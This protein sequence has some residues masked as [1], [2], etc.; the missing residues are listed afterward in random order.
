MEDG[1]RSERSKPFVA[2]IVEVVAT[3][4]VCATAIAL[5]ISIVGNDASLYLSDIEADYE[6]LTQRYVSVFKTISIPVKDE[7]AT[8]PS[9]EEMDSWLKGNESAFS[10]AVGANAYDGFAVTYKG[11][12]AHSWSYGDYAGYD[13]NTRRWYQQ[14]QS[15]GGEVTVVAPYV[16]YLSSVGQADRLTLNFTIAQR[17]SDT[18]SFDLDLNASEISDL[19][20]SRRA[21]FEDTAGLLVDSSGYIL[22]SSDVSLLSHNVNTTDDVVRQDMSNLVSSL[23]ISPAS[24]SLVEVGGTRALCYSLRSEDGNLYIAFVPVDGLFVRYLL[25]VILVSLLLIVIEVLVYQR[26]RG[27]VEE[28][29][30]RDRMI[31]QISALAFPKRVLLDMDTMTC[32]SYNLNASLGTSRDFDRLYE[33]ARASAS[34][35]DSRSELERL[36]SPAALRAMQVGDIRTER[37]SL[38]MT[39]EDGA[40]VARIYD[41]SAAV[42][43]LGRRRT[44]VILANDVTDEEHN[45]QQIAQS[46]AYHYAAV[47]VGSTTGP[48]VVVIKVDGPY[49]DALAAGGSLS[50]MHARYA[51]DILAEEY[52]SAY[53]NAV[54]ERTIDERLAT[55]MGYDLTVQRLDG[56][57]Q[58]IHIVRGMGYDQT[59]RYI[60]FVESADDQMRHQEEL[61]G[62]LRKAD[63]ATQAKSAFLS[64][65]SHD[66]R[67]P[68]NGILGF[69]DLAIHVDD[70]AKLRDYL[71]KIDVSAKLMLSL[72][73]DVLDM[74]KIESGKMELRPEAFASRMLFTTITE[75]VRLSA[76]ERNV[77]FV[78][79]LAPDYPRFILADRLRLQQLVLN[80][81]SNAIKYTPNGGHVT[82]EICSI[83]NADSPLNTLVR[84]KDDGIGMSEEFQKRMF[85][86]FAQEHQ[87]K[88]YGSQ[89]TGLGLSI[90]K[91][92][93]DL[94]GGT[95]EVTSMLGKGTE[96]VVRLAI[97]AVHA[98]R[99]EQEAPSKADARASIAG[100]R[101]LLC[102][103]NDLNAEIA[104]TVLRE[105]GGAEVERARDGREGLE[106]FENAVPGHYDAVLMDLR[107]PVMDGV[108]AA[109]AIRSLDRT[110]AHVTPIVAMTADAFVEDVKRCADAGMN[111]HISKPVDPKKL[112]SVLAE[113]IG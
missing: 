67:T 9:F 81:V 23:R 5:L 45:R 92:I 87:S 70:P 90:V 61:E 11:G 52:R 59:H 64:S 1:A 76:Q 109:C 111:G 103:D 63:E 43:N 41:I 60:F 108:D 71:A 26:N 42:T 55:S 100:R 89:G 72:I 8:D 62:A 36:T 79:S 10:D 46:I 38:N 18:V 101:I 35:E 113:K 17:Y 40:S 94:M 102:E 53:A 66:M 28:M 30:A 57:W 37:V 47:L 56:H 27:K 31:T 86:P 96:I 65:M 104:E 33:S 4:V 14:A 29:A 78:S 25:P 48:E 69:T 93:V 22:S 20:S 97:P 3:I 6:A 112:I 73:N 24:G 82:L 77:T 16:S 2:L 95:I 19:F 84:V 99:D 68:L 13:P 51:R 107:M 105:R 32:Q 21:R 39:Q 15:A 7:I 58:T 80:L 49:E 85:D 50:E 34:D 74:S 12:Y 110:D 54:S 83:S 91:Q 106:M 88:M 75:S 98:G 44:A